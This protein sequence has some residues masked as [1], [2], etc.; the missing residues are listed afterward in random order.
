MNNHVLTQIWIHALWSTHDRMPL[1][2]KAFRTQINT[3]VR[4]K[5]QESGCPVRIV[6][7]TIDHMH[8]LF[9]LGH[10]SPLSRV[11]DRIKGESTR[12]I[13]RQHFLQFPFS[14]QTGYCAL[15]VSGSMVQRV[16]TFIRDQDLQ[17]QKMTASQEYG[18]F[19]TQCGFAENCP[20][21]KQI[22]VS[23]FATR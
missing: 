12:W 11:M 22:P 23:L 14:W 5:L 2:K 15:S 19:L 13:N 18:L 16:E 4:Y 17:H 20:Q 21:P 6:N 7:C 9:Q 8:A 10:D 3:Y 1:L